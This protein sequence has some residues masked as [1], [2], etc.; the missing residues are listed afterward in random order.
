MGKDS[1]VNRGQNT[2]GTRVKRND[3]V[4]QNIANQNKADRSTIRD[5]VKRLNTKRGN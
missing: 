4:T 1:Q 2:Q 5:V 3:A